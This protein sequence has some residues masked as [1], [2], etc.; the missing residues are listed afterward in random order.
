MLAARELQPLLPLE[1][2]EL[3]EGM[4]VARCGGEWNPRMPGV[5]SDGGHFSRCKRGQAKG[6]QEEGRPRSTPATH[7]SSL[8]VAV[9]SRACSW[10]VNDKDRRPRERVGLLLYTPKNVE[11]WR[12][13]CGGGHF[14]TT[15]SATLTDTS[16]AAHS[17]HGD[18]QCTK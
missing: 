4:E 14:P 3:E 10:L 1:A 12:N 2:V 9:Q 15:P 7:H 11:E 16:V 8:T 6:G 17:G 5:T 13:L 18:A